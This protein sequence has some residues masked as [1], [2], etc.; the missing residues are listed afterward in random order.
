[1]QILK[2]GAIFSPCEYKKTCHK[3]YWFYKEIQICHKIIGGRRGCSRGLFDCRGRLNNEKII[4]M[5]KRECAR[6]LINCTW[7]LK[8]TTKGDDL[9]GD[10]V[11]LS[12][13]IAPHVSE[14][15]CGGGGIFEVQPMR[16]AVHITWLGAQINFGDLTPYLTYG[17]DVPQDCLI[18]QRVVKCESILNIHVKLIDCK[19]GLNTYAA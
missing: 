16:T 6:E 10:L 7:R 2:C 1:M 3:I 9:Q 4:T 5:Q 15:K 14:P 17:E 13:P 19:T 11:Y 8:Y 18:A 12:W